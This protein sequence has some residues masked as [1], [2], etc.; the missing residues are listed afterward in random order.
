MNGIEEALR[1]EFAIVVIAT[2]I[3]LIIVVRSIVN[4]VTVVARE[5]SRREIAA[6][7]ADGLMTPEQGEKLV[8]AD[9]TPASEKSNR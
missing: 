7:V 3:L 6:Y 9:M 5:R 4:V 2:G 1:E 8:T